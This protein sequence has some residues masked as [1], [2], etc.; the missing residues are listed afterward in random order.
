MHAYLALLPPLSA[1]L[2]EREYLEALPNTPVSGDY[3]GAVAFA[4]AECTIQRETM[5]DRVE[6][7]TVAV[8]VTF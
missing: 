8:W 1:V 7:P 4:C 6:P 5:A 3:A 2:C